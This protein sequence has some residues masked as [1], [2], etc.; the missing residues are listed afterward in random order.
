MK[1][2]ARVIG[3]STVMVIVG[4]LLLTQTSM[5]KFIAGVIT[6][7]LYDLTWSAIKESQHAE[8]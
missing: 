3:S 7:A 1:L 8:N 4:L 6:M 2:L 5:D